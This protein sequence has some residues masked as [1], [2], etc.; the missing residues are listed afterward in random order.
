MGA[1]SRLHLAALLV[2][3]LAV[4][5]PATAQ[6]VPDAFTASVTRYAALH[7]EQE[8]RLPRPPVTMNADALHARSA[9]LA[10]AIR[11]HREAQQGDIFTADVAALIRFRIGRALWKYEMDAAELL[12]NLADD[13]DVPPLAVHAP[14]PIYGGYMIWAWMLAE[15]PPLPSE[16]EYRLAGSTLVLV[17][18]DAAL[19]VDFLP[20]ALRVPASATAGGG[21]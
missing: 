21:R 3:L 17:D 2:P 11:A 9:K 5:A 6:H 15:L 1:A 19:I 14:F 7:R 16:L 12:A 4:S 10:D 20:G 8:R 13:R 18:V